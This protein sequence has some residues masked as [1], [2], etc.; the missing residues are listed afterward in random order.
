MV[1]KMFFNQITSIL[2]H[3]T[4]PIKPKISFLFDLSPNGVIIVMEIN[5][6]KGGVL[7]RYTVLCFV[8]QNVHPILTSDK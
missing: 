6:T 1:L 2:R 8:T 5:I 4:L 7:A 3:N